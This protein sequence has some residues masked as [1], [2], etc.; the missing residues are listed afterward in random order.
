MK[1]PR[2]F[3]S[4]KAWKKI[5]ERDFYFKSKWE[6]LYALHLEFLKSKKLIQEWDYEPETFWFLEIKR[7]VRSYMP[8]F[9]VLELSGQR[10]WVEVKGFMDSKSKTK[11]ARFKRF[12][13]NERMVVV[14]KDWFEKR[15]K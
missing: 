14:E 2:V 5:A 1:L 3:N 8:D 15:K 6:Y 10:Y 4:Q 7:G 11:L 13:P 12:Y 9:R